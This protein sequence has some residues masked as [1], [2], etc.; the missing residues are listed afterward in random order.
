MKEL[1]E[2]V[3]QGQKLNEGELMYLTDGHEVD[4]IAM[5]KHRWQEEVMSIIECDG[6]YLALVWRSPYTE[7]GEREFYEQPYFVKPVEKM[8]KVTEWERV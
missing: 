6:D 3:K 1:F 7:L 8:V 4:R 2:K 5:C